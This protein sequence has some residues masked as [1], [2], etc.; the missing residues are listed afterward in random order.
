MRTN[1]NLVERAVILARAMVRTLVY[2]AS[3]TFVCVLHNYHL[4]I[5]YADSGCNSISIFEAFIRIFY[6]AC[7]IIYCELSSG[8]VLYIVPLDAETNMNA[9]ICTPLLVYAV[10]LIR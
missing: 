3:D 10:T 4:K 8:S 1:L 7:K 5:Y 6:S 9:A 2:S